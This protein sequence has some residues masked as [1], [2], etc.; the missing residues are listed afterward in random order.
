[1]SRQPVTQ[2]FITDEPEIN[3]KATDYQRKEDEPSSENVQA[4]DP[5]VL[6]PCAATA[7]IFLYAQGTSIVCCHH[8]TLAIERIFSNHA[9]E[10][11]LLAVD[12]HSKLGSGR[13]AVSYD[14]GQVA[15]VWDLLTGDEIARFV[16]YE[17]LTAAVWMG[18]G[19]AAFGNTKGSIILFEPITSEHVSIR[20]IDQIKVTALAP[21]ADC[22]TFAIG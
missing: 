1:M 14:A 3:S 10:V 16:S 22:Q 17:P 15:I 2:A 9:D 18:N 13:H 19:N 20:T 6:I 21:L 8:D 12:N 4:S 7:S 11:I 5:N